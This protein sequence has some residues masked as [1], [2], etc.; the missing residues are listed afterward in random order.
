MAKCGANAL[1]MIL[2]ADDSAPVGCRRLSPA[3]RQRSTSA[4]PACWHRRSV[5]ASGTAMPKTF[6]R[7]SGLPLDA[8][9]Q[10]GS[11]VSGRYRIEAKLGAGGMGEI[12]L[13]RHLQLDNSDASLR[14][15]LALELPQPPKSARKAALAGLQQ[16]EAS[17]DTLKSSMGE[18]QEDSSRDM[19]LDRAGNFVAQAKQLRRRL[20][21]P[22]PFD[23]G[24]YRRLGGLGE[25]MVAGSPMAML[26]AY[27]YLYDD[28]E[29]WLG[30]RLFAYPYRMPAHPRGLEH[31]TGYTSKL[32]GVHHPTQQLRA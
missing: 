26:K 29:V 24:E 17:F 9:L 11:V 13:A 18:L 8:E 19:M 14:Q 21:K 1:V 31:P 28:R 5:R 10:L 20:A 3:R 25:W 4:G 2:A 15:V 6:T 16:L 7:A 30:L 22:R 12:Y 32:V 27:D 23:K